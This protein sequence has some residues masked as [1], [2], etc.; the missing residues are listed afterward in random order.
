MRK[1]L[2]ILLAASVLFGGC[3]D[4][5]NNVENKTKTSIEPQST[6]KK[7]DEKGIEELILSWFENNHAMYKATNRYT[8]KCWITG[9]LYGKKAH[10]P[11]LYKNGESMIYFAFVEETGEIYLHYA[12]NKYIPVNRVKILDNSKYKKKA[13]ATMK[14]VFGK[15]KA[16]KMAYFDT[17]ERDG[18]E[19]FVYGKFKSSELQLVFL[20]DIDTEE[21]YKWDLPE[22]AL[23]KYTNDR[24]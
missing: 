18:T 12:D 17:I 19:Y 15:K 7:M 14:K 22:D 6:N 20:V 23:N 11:I 24:G 9:K 13:I 3:S 10:F 5:D 8:C 2:C 16:E 21:I 1:L 4:K